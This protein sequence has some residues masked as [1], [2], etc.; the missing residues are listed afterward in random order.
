MIRDGNSP[1]RSDWLRPSAQVI[2]RQLGC[3]AVLIHL[4]TNQ[5]YELNATGRRIWELL[6]G[7]VK[8]D[9][10]CKQVRQEFDVDRTHAAKDIDNLLS[11]LSAENLITRDRGDHD[12]AGTS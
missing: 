8:K 2:S 4:E 9:D 12:A 7:G 5:I 1:D 11:T 6:Q 10:I 3:G